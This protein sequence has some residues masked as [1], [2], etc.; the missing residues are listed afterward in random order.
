MARREFRVSGVLRVSSFAP[1]AATT[2][3]SDAPLMIDITDRHR[4]HFRRCAAI[5]VAR[6]LASTVVATS[7]AACAASGGV[8]PAPAASA[9]AAPTVALPASA[10]ALIARMRDHYA[11]GGWLRTLTF[12]QRTRVLRPGGVRDSSTWL[13]ALQAPSRL[14]IDIEPRSAGNG[15]IFTA[16]STYRIRNGQ[17]A[18][19]TADANPLMP[20]VAA[21]Y[22]QPVERTMLELAREHYDTTRMRADRWRGHPVAVVGSDRADDLASPQFWVDLDRLV[23]VRMI[24]PSG[25]AGGRMLDI[26]MNDY[27]P[28]GH[29]LV[30]TRVDVIAG[31]DTVQSE[32]YRDV[33]VDVPLDPALFEP[34]SWSSAKHWA[35]R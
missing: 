21:L 8:V 6:A 34:A 17:V 32:E 3:H 27:R 1:A 16:D 31:T 22:V 30:A 12:V 4:L 20:F 2:H 33:R 28:F 9:V 14:R 25:Q 26:H 5:A 29:A 23:L 13:E 7:M 24:L 10:S 11:S 35:G 19:A 15:I 18:G